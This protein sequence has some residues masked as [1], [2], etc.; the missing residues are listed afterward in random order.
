MVERWREPLAARDHQ[1]SV[2]CD[3]QPSEP[4]TCPAFLAGLKGM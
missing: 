4:S 1:C 2:I 3:L